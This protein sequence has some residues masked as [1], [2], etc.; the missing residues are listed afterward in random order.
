[1]RFLKLIDTYCTLFFPPLIQISHANCGFVGLQGGSS[2]TGVR[3]SGN[4][5]PENYLLSPGG[6]L[7]IEW[8]STNRQLFVAGSFDTAGDVPASN[9]AVFQFADATPRY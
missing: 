2:A 8:D 9:I 7:A 5:V 3:V 6:V 1:M 4:G